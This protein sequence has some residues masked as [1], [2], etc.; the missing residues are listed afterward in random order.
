MLNEREFGDLLESR[1]FTTIFP[2]SLSLE[3]QLLLYRNARVIAGESGTAMLNRVFTQPDTRELLVGAEFGIES[4]HDI[5][6]S[7]IG[8]EM[9]LVQV[10][11]GKATTDDRG[12]NPPAWEL[13]LAHVKEALGGLAL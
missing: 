8:A 2:E 4:N 12:P 3:E 6:R 9:D 10:V 11:N 7:M 13:D 1:G 5:I